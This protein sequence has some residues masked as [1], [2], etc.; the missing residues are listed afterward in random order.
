MSQLT[1]KVAVITGAASGIG[2]AIA[3]KCAREGMKVVLAD[4]EESPLRQT[5]KEMTTKG[6]NVLGILTDVR[7]LED[8]ENLAKEVLDHFGS[9]DLLCNNAGVG[10]AVNSSTHVW[11]N[12]LADWRWIFD[13]N[14]F[15]IINGIHVFVPIMLKQD[16]TCYLINT[17]SMAGIIPPTIGMSIYSVSKYAVIALTESLY[18]ELKRQGSNIK[19][20][21]LCPGFVKTNLTESERNRP[22]NYEPKISENLEMQSFLNI[23]RS[24]VENGISPEEVA[25]ELFRNLD[26]EK[27]YIATDHQVFMKKNVTVRMEAILKDLSKK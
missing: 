1:N 12:T 19:V 27:L 18:H 10:F 4:I 24:S 14:V 6:A 20:L 3:E 16:T 7:K 26:G 22:K 13:V 8:I 5:E 11:E 9:V 21:A 2:R 17:A 23:F 15:G 25:E